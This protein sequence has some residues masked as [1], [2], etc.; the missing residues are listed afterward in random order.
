MNVYPNPSHD[1][2]NLSFS[3]DKASDVIVSITD[4]T[5]KRLYSKS[6]KTTSGNNSIPIDV[7]VISKGVY[8]LSLSSDMV[9]ATRRIVIEK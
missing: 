9:N 3:M 5:G 2:V 1:E 4:L 7:S 8:V 6:V